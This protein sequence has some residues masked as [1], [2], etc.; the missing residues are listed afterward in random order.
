MAETKDVLW[1]DTKEGK[2]GEALLG[3]ALDAY[4]V[5]RKFLVKNEDGTE[6]WKYY[7][8]GLDANGRP[9]G[10]VKIAHPE[11]NGANK[12][13]AKYLDAEGKPTVRFATAGG[14]KVFY[15]NGLEKEWRAESAD[16]ASFRKLIP[17]EI[18]GIPRKKPK[19]IN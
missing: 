13:P 16:L 18:D 10:R 14:K 6:E 2:E 12:R 11:V 4:G 19:P 8:K 7:P 9:V 3:K 17:V 5:Q 15:F 1:I